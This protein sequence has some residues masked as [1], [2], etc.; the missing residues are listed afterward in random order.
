MVVNCKSHP[1]FWIRRLAVDMTGA[2]AEAHVLKTRPKKP[3]G[4]PAANQLGALFSV[5][6]NA[7]SFESLLPL[8]TLKNI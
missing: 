5:I 2:G 1:Q 6:G 7:I 3:L 4:S 8:P